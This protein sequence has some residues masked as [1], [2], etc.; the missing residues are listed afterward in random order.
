MSMS[1]QHN[2]LTSRD[3]YKAHGGGI[4]AATAIHQT[5]KVG[6]VSTPAASI[7]FCAWFRASGHLYGK[8]SFLSRFCGTRSAESTPN[9]WPASAASL[10]ERYLIAVPRQGIF[11]IGWGSE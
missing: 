11:S 4:V 10:R 9:G 8:R 6:G 7:C 1:T 5:T 3:I 2:R